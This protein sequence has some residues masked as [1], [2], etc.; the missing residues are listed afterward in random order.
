MSEPMTDPHDRHEEHEDDWEGEEAGPQ[1][2]W[3][4]VI[5]LAVVVLI[6]F[7]L[8][9]ITAANGVPAS[10]LEAAR[11]QAAELESENEDLRSQVA[12][13]E[14][15]QSDAAPAERPDD[16]GEAD[17]GDGEEGPASSQGRGGGLTYVVKNGDNLSR[18]AKKFYDDASLGTFIAEA[19]SLTDPADL[20]VGQKLVIPDRP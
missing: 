3:G 7:L 2:L 1:V 11:G 6:A 14:S 8:G 4:R 12:L 15:N 13:L 20:S 17:D 16:Q 19:N 5:A 9:R 10:D 18:I